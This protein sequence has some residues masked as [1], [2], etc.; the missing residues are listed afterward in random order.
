MVPFILSA[1][2]Q[3][4]VSLFLNSKNWVLQRFVETTMHCTLIFSWSIWFLPE[5]VYYP[6]FWPWYKWRKDN[7]GIAILGSSG[8]KHMVYHGVH[9]VGVLHRPSPQG[10]LW[11][12]SIV[13]TWSLGASWVDDI[14]G[15]DISSGEI[16]ARNKCG[17]PKTLRFLNHG[18]LRNP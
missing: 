17:Y 1:C 4:A 15:L 6:I 10:L 5:R 14:L 3:L 16:E 8:E 12:S 13:L 11:T 2:R 7:D 9:S 18:S